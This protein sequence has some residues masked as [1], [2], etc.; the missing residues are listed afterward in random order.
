[1]SSTTSSR[2]YQQSQKP[3]IVQ[4]RDSSIDS[5]TSG[6]TLD[7]ASA[8]YYSPTRSDRSSMSSNYHSSSQSDASH[9]PDRVYKFRAYDAGS[10][11]QQCDHS[12]QS[13]NIE[14]ADNF[15]GT[16]K[17]SHSDKIKLIHHNGRRA[18]DPKLVHSSYATSGDYRRIQKHSEKRH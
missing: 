9:E 10:S 2:R 4:N 1:M 7:R 13:T 3:V 15:E 12:K 14:L 6:S 17:Y 18:E 16:F 11:P 5:R 8:S